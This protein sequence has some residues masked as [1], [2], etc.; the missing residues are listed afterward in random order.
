M[1]IYELQ[2]AV[3]AMLEEPETDGDRTLEDYLR[4]LW[5]LVQE[6]RAADVTYEWVLSALRRSFTVDPAPYE[7]AW[8]QFTDPPDEIR[9]PDEFEFL[10]RTLL[11]QIAD[12]RRMVGN[13]LDNPHAGLGV[14]SPTGNDWYNF[15][16]LVY[17]ERAMQ[18]FVDNLEVGK[19][20]EYEHNCSWRALAIILELGRLYE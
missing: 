13:Q 5:R 6:H 17:L 19:F 8:L 18:G 2:E 10:R 3:E 1:T 16:P 4:A 15:A 7:Q 12:L 14:H 11:F 9:V 20:T